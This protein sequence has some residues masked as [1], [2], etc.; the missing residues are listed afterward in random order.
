MAGTLT[1]AFSTSQGEDGKNNNE[2]KNNKKINIY[3]MLHVPKV[4]FQVLFTNTS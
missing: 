1:S 2:N 3:I 4:L